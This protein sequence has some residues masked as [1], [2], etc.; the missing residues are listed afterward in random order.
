MNAKYEIIKDAV[1][2]YIKIFD[3][4]RR[5]ID[6]PIFQRLRR[7]SQNTGVQYVYPCATHTRF[8]HSL[9]V[10]HIAG[11]F[12]ER[13]L[14]QIPNV[15]EKTKRRYFYLMRLWGLTHDIGQ[16]PFSHL[17]DDLILKPKY[18]TDHEKIGAKIL[19]ESSQLPD[20][21]VPE[22]GIQITLDEVARLFEV[23]AIEN[24]P[25]KKRIG[26]S[27]VT[28]KILYYVCRG[29]YSADIMDFLLRD[30]YFTGAGY[31]N[32]DWQR[33]IYAS[34][35][36]KDKV[37]LD[38]KGEEAFDSL[39]LARLFMFSTVY[40]HRTTRAAVKVISYFLNEAASAF[41]N[42]RDFIGNVDEYSIL[43]ESF[44][45]LHPSLKDSAYR[46]R[47][48]ERKIPYTRYYERSEQMSMDL[49]D[50][51]IAEI[52]TKRTRRNLPEN[53]RERLPEHAF[54]VDTPKIPLNPMFDQEQYIFLAD[55]ESQNGYK[56]RKIWETSWGSLRQQIF[57][58]RLFIHDDYHAYENEI[59]KAFTQ[60]IERTHF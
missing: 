53:L 7:I 43:D 24:W 6:T 50:K 2:G 1:H 19:R 37:L 46:K 9:G 39:I 42:F 31:G 17:F 11:V 44:L 41:N 58:I 32:I 13:L 29:P 15:S 48:L 5:I 59:T 56:T 45:L 21:V 26:R 27:D 14:D 4:E 38:P 57:L 35:P 22:N 52:M 20:K 36:H 33:L 30:S 3:H 12:T 40:Y 10:M 23:K 55:P 54:F 8:S 60:R 25:L 47:L 16:G 49:S 51:D 18:N 28:G 34:I